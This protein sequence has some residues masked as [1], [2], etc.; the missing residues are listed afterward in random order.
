MSTTSGH[1]QWRPP[2]TLTKSWMQFR[3]AL[4]REGEGRREGGG[5]RGEKFDGSGRREARRWEDGEG[6]GEGGSRVGEKIGER[7]RGGAK[8]GGREERREG[9]GKEGR[10]EGG[11]RQL[12]LQYDHCPSGLHCLI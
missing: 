9:G 12:R 7:G 2:A 1:N 5:R 6:R 4:R 8:V 11:R 3:L 10:R